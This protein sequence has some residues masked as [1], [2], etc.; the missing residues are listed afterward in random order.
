MESS[1]R[2]LFIDMVFYTFIFENN[3]IT[4]F[5][6]STVMPKIGLTMRLPKTGVSFYYPRQ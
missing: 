1:R 2:D 3:Q 4:P 5:P 6:C